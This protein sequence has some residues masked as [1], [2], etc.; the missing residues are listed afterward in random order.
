MQQTVTDSPLLP[1]GVE[2]HGFVIEAYD[3]AAA[4]SMLM[5][6][7]TD[8]IAQTQVAPFARYTA[9]ISYRQPQILLNIAA[10]SDPANSICLRVVQSVMLAQST[11]ERLFQCVVELFA[12][13]RIE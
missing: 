8:G 4:L 1:I 11:S 2:G 3:L 12:G 13:I 6:K 7:K 5:I 9:R 10:R